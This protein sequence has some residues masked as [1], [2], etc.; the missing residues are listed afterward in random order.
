MGKLFTLRYLLL[1][2]ILG[3]INTRGISQTFTEDFNY[4][5]ASLI[6][7][8]GWTANSGAGTNAITV[9]SS[10]LTYPGSP[11]SGIGNAVTMA[12]NGEDDAKNFTPISSGSIYTSLL[13]NVTSAQTGGDYFAGLI[14]G[15][16]ASPAFALRV[17]I[18]STTGGF[19]FG[20]AKGTAT[21]VYE[22][23]V[24]SFG[25]TYLLAGKYIYNT[26]T[27][28]DDLISLWINP[29]LGST[30]SS[31][32]LTAGSGTA[33]AAAAGISGSFLR[34]GSST[35]ASA[36]IVDG[37]RAGT[38][39]ASVTSL[40]LQPTTTAITS[41][42]NPS[43]SGQ[44]VTFTATVS[45]ASGTPTGTVTFFDGSTNLGS[46]SLSGN[47]A[48]FSTSTLTA[49]S[50]NI[51]ST[52]NGDASNASSTSSVLSQ[53]V[54]ASSGVTLSSSENPSNAGQS[55]TFTA[56][57]T[58][59][60]GT[61]T[62][63]VDFFDGVT[64]IGSSTISGTS[65]TLSTSALLA[66]SHSITATY[67][68]DANN[69]SSTSSILTQ[70]VKAAT[71][72]SLISSV[73]P[74]SAGQNVT[75]TATVSTAS[76]TPA[77]SVQ[78]F[79]GVTS[80]G[81]GTLS[82]SS[83]TLSTSL[84]SEGSHTITATYNGN[85]NYT[86]STSSVLTQV[87][88]AASAQKLLEDF[89]Y[90]A[91]T[92]LTSNGYI[93]FSGAGTNA[94]TV[95]SPSLTY[96]GSPSSGVSNAITMTTSG[97]DASLTFSP[98]IS[99]GNAY[100]SL[101]VN[102]SSAQST[103]DYFFS[104]YDGSYVTKVFIKASGSGFVFG[105]A[106]AS[107]TVSYDGTVRPFNTTLLVVLKYT[108][109]AATTDDLV[110]LFVEP[111]LGGTEPSPTIP[112]IGSG[113]TDAGTFNRIAFRQGSG[114]AA[115]AQIVDG[116]RV[117]TTWASVT[118]VSSPATTSISPDA[119][120]AG[121]PGFT[122]TVNGTN[123]INGSAIT[124][125]GISRTTTFVNSTQLTT[126]IAASDL[127]PAGTVA[128][129]VTTT[130]AA[131][132]S[133]TQTFTINPAV[134]GYF[135]LQS[136]LTDF[137][138][139]C[140]N[141]I[142]GPYS[143][144]IDGN[145]MDGS[146]NSTITIAALPGFT[147]SET[148]DGTY[149][150]TLDI[151][152]AGASFSGKVIYVKFNPTAVQSYNGNIVL[153]GGGVS[154]YPVP[155]TGSGIYNAP[156]VTTGTSSAVAATTATL[157][158]TISSIGCAPLTTYGI[159]YSANSGFPEGSGTKVPSTNLDAANNFSS[160][161]TG[162]SPNTRYYY[163]AY[164]TN[165]IGS[166]YG[167]QLAFTNTPLPVPMASQPDL[168]FT[169]GFA[170]IANWSNFFISGD[171]A[172]HW[173]GLSANTTGTIPD[174]IKLTAATNS[175]Q[176]ATF[177]S[178]GGVQKGTDQAPPTES[179]VL[180]S[181]GSPDNTTSA[182]I[183]FYMDFTGVNAGTLS[184]DYQTI[185]NSTGNRNGSMRVYATTDG[186]TFTELPFADV[187]DFTNNVSVSGSKTNIAL[188]E[189][190]NNN[191]HAR[192]RF[193]YHNGSGNTGSGSRPKISIDNVTVTAVATTPCT[194]PTAQPTS[195]VFGTVN[196]VSIQGSFTAASPAPD[197]YLV[198]MST[199][200]SLTSNPIDGQIY[201]LGD[202]VGDGSVISRGS[203]TTFTASGLSASTTYY[204]FVFSVNG[205]CTGGPKYLVTNP[206]TGTTNTAAG[207]P[208]CSAP[209]SQATDLAF[210]N[211][212]TNT[213]QGSF[214]ATTADE[215]LV[216]KSTSSTL[217]VNPANGHIYNIGDVVGN[218]EVIHRNN[219]TS[220]TASGLA[221]ETT[222]YFFVF[223]INSQGCIN[224]PAYNITNPLNGS[225]QTSPLQPCVAPSSQPTLLTLTPSN[226]SISGTFNGSATADNYLIVRSTSAT[227]SATPA[228]NTDYTVGSSLG[229][230]V[231]AGNS[232]STSFLATN[233][234]PLTNYYFFV[235]AS[236]KNCSGGT[237]YLTATPLTGNA[238]TNNAI[239]YN[240]Y[241]GTLHSHSDYSDG[242]K[243]HPGYTPADDYNYAITSECMD[244]LGISEH[245]HYSTVN[246]PGNSIT[247]FH[248]GSVQAKDF[249]AANPNFVALYGM[250]WGVISGGG[251]VVVYGD[252]MD[253]LFG[254]ESGSGGWGP[255]N[256]YDV[257][258]PKSTYTG[259]AGLFKTVNDFADQN[260]FATLAH[261]NSTD[262]NNIANTPYKDTADNA[263]T[264]VAVESGPAFSTNTTYSDPTTMSYLWYYQTLL[265]KGYHLG[266]TM[267]HDNHNTTFGHTTRART[268]VLAPSL[269][270]TEIIK[271][272]RDMHFYATEDCDTK[273]DFT[274]NTKIMGS[275]F[276]DRN[277]P[278]I[279]VNLTDAT[280]NT[281]SAIIRVMYGKP[282]SGVMAA[283]IDSVI[284]NHL[285]FVD[286]NLPNGET[287]YY[288]IDITNGTSRIVTSPIWYT[289][290]CSVSGETTKYACSSYDWNGQTYTE[291]GTYTKPGFTTS[292]G[293][294][295][296]DI[297]HLI[298]TTPTTG[299]TTAVACDNF[300]WYGTTYTESGTPT[301]VLKERG[302][303]D[304]TVTLHLTINHSTTTDETKVACDSYTWNGNTYTT[305]GDYTFES[306]NAEGCTNTATLHLTINHSTTTEETKVA[307]DSYTWNGNTYTTSGDY[308]YP[309]T[310]EQGCINTATLHLTINH[311]TTTEETKVT[312]D[313]YTWNG[314][315]YT[316]S[317]DYTYPST[318]EQGC[319][320][321][322]TLHLTI[323]H[324]T[325]TE[326]T[327]VACDSYTWNGNTYT[328][329]GDYTYPSTNEQGCTNTATLHLTINHSTTTEETKVACD[330]YT[331]NGQI[332]TTSGDYNFESTNEQ[333]C[334]N[335]A[336]LHLTIN[337]S[338]TSSETQTA[339]DSYTWNGNTYTE[340]GNYT[341]ESTNAQGCTNTAT[342]HL[343]INHSS[344]SSETQTACDSYTWHGTTYTES[345]N[346]T[347]ESTNAEGCTNTATLHLTVNPKP[348]VTIP[349]VYVLPQGVTANTVYIGYIPA[350]TLTVTA[351]PGGGTPF[352]TPAA[353]T[354]SWT[355]G[356]GLI[357]TGA[358]NQ[359]SVKISATGLTTSSTVTVMITDSNG[360]TATAFITVDINDVSCGSKS[361]KVNV[362]ILSKGKYSTSCISPNAVAGNLTG[363]NYLGA[364]NTPLRTSN[365]RTNTGI[366]VSAAKQ[367]VINSFEVTVSPNPSATDFKLV[368]QSNSTEP[369]SI[370]L[371]DVSGRVINTINKIQ[372]NETVTI[373]NSLIGGT[374]FAE[375]VQGK[376]RKVIKLIKL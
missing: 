331:W 22:T 270:Q 142:A 226:S 370:R 219:T 106:K 218:A 24:R 350:A 254:W 68:G 177:G 324:S 140:T 116:I 20:C 25:T 303:C 340:S 328:T 252:G 136:P 298:I 360:C 94:I 361:D 72:V 321:T 48:T 268:A 334:I 131:T 133:N 347:F 197:Q 257:Y 27:T 167:T 198:V 166:T 137:G 7:A 47:A 134:G 60:S 35:A 122:L 179:I 193:Y 274:I 375:V 371:Q 88:N 160:D 153:N 21:P 127:S 146:N 3:S 204:F 65:A 100:A 305:S 89:N 264:G 240:Y 276:S 187:L 255:T 320:N 175:F 217:T 244:F 29:T 172:N 251:H 214:S 220:F 138:N 1:A 227:L 164:A 66:G 299:D 376:N 157:S 253:K 212:S 84:L 163:K 286:N 301:K 280:T 168:S 13:V 314:N 18:K 102:V 191:S 178:S 123:F 71:S 96:A 50:H 259:P 124:W 302:G 241:F 42:L 323:N 62:G 11:A 87:V 225:Q 359:K 174:G 336:T 95:T 325:T 249:N 215:Y 327:K 309:S 266:P 182:A 108:F 44:S 284:G 213:I 117:G 83:A 147:Y 41:S 285:Y 120:T 144:T 366:E 287:G 203:S 199:S 231:V 292:A 352:A 69:T 188:P 75:F 283:K 236:N 34:Q 258:V 296:T 151:T 237:K 205:V 189:S 192:L 161:I 228:D 358:H 46:G 221:A 279:S 54:T 201:N 4:S 332:Y 57:I 368:I 246:N 150:N 318:N 121:S 170:D 78:F 322:A 267:D 260:T 367:A 183:D 53:S 272:M 114:T 31:P 355:A 12:T 148:P 345:G 342:L 295:S 104:L 107:G 365:T 143:F 90:T 113:A 49:G 222:Y 14:T 165:S 294:D 184:F 135:T 180:L 265:A 52:Y 343:T 289:R 61:P 304:S 339:C 269:S 159:E 281:S 181:T 79:D 101:F 130:G 32:N 59:T 208:P 277:A 356:S 291:S 232:S 194:S 126:F 74:S 162:L 348:T 37:I 362:C 73:N 38:T 233:L 229:G 86:G 293:C 99:S 374:Y 190:F 169:E 196:D 278:S 76:G 158:G 77:G 80:L 263:I 235:F 55:V 239:V 19:L 308:T 248:K 216:L 242:N 354:Y 313:S 40:A 373:G 273:V 33:D 211:V 97:E 357:I 319:T 141:T 16:S 98:T 256:N 206:L 149:T 139:V 43:L 81:S 51:T 307:C 56:T 112:A 63:S 2:L 67:N 346:Y 315:T 64:N 341:F 145:S 39:W 351:N 310:N 210:T 330:S 6:T 306:V 300:T 223:S 9:T 8:N 128:I 118:P 224:G 297:L 250:E 119:A 353:Y 195:I 329:S 36:Q 282:G 186:T 238:A 129:G 290:T 5:P 82:A 335:T 110:S 200:N 288:Y 93:A 369:I 132:V 91:G 202:N 45:A 185:N 10:G 247:D 58:T 103:G 154:N 372:R 17:Y 155:A 92:T 125:K 207:L 109:N 243:D 85:A 316:T 23:T 333:G 111:V 230:G 15:T 30:E 262:F 261:P 28:T 105:I 156:T 245:N 176:G 311:S 26:G 234:S 349:T 173:G 171:G 152:Y 338:S 312:C 275:V 70:V 317:G 209:L 337:H 363:S 271:A 326:E 364:C 115:S 344:T